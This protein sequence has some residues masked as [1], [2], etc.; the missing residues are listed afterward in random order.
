MHRSPGVFFDH[1]HGKTHSI[2]KYLFAARIIPY[3]GSWLDFEFDPKDLLYVRIDRRRKLPVSSLLYSLPSEAD[4]K[5]KA[6][7]EA[8]GETL[9]YAD[10]KRMD[11][12]EILNTF[13]QKFLYEKA[14]KGWVTNFFPDR[15]K[16]IRCI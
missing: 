7:K 12:E 15:F 9:S 4:L 5:L 16:G 1:D 14:D 6:A 10:I 8:N 3:R 2:G 13:Y 11:K